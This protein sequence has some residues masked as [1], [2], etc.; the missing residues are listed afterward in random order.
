VI[1]LPPALR[2]ALAPLRGKVL[3]IE[4]RELGAGPQVTLC[5]LGLAP[6][7]GRPDVT[8]R[9]GLRDYLAIALREEDPDT[10]FF[11]RQLVIE[12]DT[13]LGLEI[14]NALDA[15]SLESLL[16]LGWLKHRS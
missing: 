16:P 1:P 12:G 8:F 4:I 7:F 6:A 14:K 3:R 15:L 13:A 11:R 9:A 2:S 10:L 5:G